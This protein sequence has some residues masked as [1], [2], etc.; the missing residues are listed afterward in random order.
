MANVKENER[1]IPIKNYIIA[2]IAVIAIVLLTWYGF[3]WYN[4][5]KEN[6]VSTSYLVTEKIITKEINNLDEV[7]DVFSEVPSSYYIY[8]SY[9]GS[10]EIY[11]LEQDI[12]SIIKEYNLS[13]NFYFL[14][15][16]SIKDDKGFIDKINESLNLED[17]KI[18]SVPTIIYFKEGKATSIIKHEGKGIMNSND[19]QKMLDVSDINKK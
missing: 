9:T 17:I 8:I 5:I 13:D 1:Y 2:L 18:S 19:F 15:V 6:K 14:N 16:S 3:S 10:E 11:A 7:T 4:V 12:S